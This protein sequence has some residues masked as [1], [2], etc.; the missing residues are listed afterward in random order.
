MSVVQH[1]VLLKWKPRTTE[2]QIRDAFEHA[3]TLL[4]E[5]DVVRDVTLGRNRGQS[6]HGFTHALVVNVADEDAL[7]SYLDHPAR[8]GYI[9]EWLKPI[10]D[11]RIEVDVAVDMAHRRDPRRDWE[12][13]SSIGMGPPVDD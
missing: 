7:W 13:G 11:Q 3:R 4:R 8:L 12:W 2:E 1:I 9:D 10:E 5:I 6:S